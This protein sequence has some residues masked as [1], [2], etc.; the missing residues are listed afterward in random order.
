MKL[1][2]IPLLLLPA[3]FM[4]LV[5]CGGDTASPL[6]T[7]TSVLSTATQVPPT[8]TATPIPVPTDSP[9]TLPG[10]TISIDGENRD[11]GLI[12]DRTISI[13]TVTFKVSAYLDSNALYVMIESE[14]PKGS[15]EKYELEIVADGH[16]YEVH[17]GPRW[18]D[19]LLKDVDNNW[20]DVRGPLKSKAAYSTVAEFRIALSDLSLPLYVELP[21][22]EIYSKENVRTNIRLF[23]NPLGPHASSVARQANPIPTP[24]PT[25]KS[26]LPSSV[27]SPIF[28]LG[29]IPEVHIECLFTR[30]EIVE[31][32][33][34][35]KGYHFLS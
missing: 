28:D 35:H 9:T 10:I 7:Y 6:P 23:S 26:I 31:L 13:S 2:S 18:S 16:L 22:M 8:P 32:T 12:E 27:E 1:K 34:P 20:S 30:P 24:K 21:G 33:C 3:A 15:V 14:L 17:W 5:A 29:P 4:V 11:W 25:A 19:I